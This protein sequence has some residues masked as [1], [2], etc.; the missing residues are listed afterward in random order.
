MKEEISY[1][2][3]VNSGLL[4][5]IISVSLIRLSSYRGGGR[6]GHSGGSVIRRI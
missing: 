6:G 3:I 4:V 5:F 1:L 2:R